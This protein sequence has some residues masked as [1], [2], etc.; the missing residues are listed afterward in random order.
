MEQAGGSMEQAGKI[1]K[2]IAETAVQRKIGILGGS[3]DPIHMG[4]IHIAEA[5]FQEFSLDEVLF[6]PAGHSPNK[7]ECRMSSAEDRARMAELAVADYPA[8]HVSRMELEAAGTSY[9]YLTMAR[10]AEEHPD[11]KLYFIMGADSLD[12]FDQWCHPEIICRYA[13]IL[14]AVRDDLEQEAICSKIAQIKSIFPAEIYPLKG[15]KME[16]SS[17]EIRAA[18]RSGNS[19]DLLPERVAEYIREHGLYHL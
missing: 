12:Y 15:S 18:V 10:L 7:D 9:T 6:M 5:A 2:G 8:F 1:G 3:F 14:V 16:V 4:H 19:S 13:V 11:W 17:S